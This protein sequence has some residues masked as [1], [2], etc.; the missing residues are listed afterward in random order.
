MW[1]SCLRD[2]FSPEAADLFRL[3]ANENAEDLGE[4]A[5]QQGV[6]GGLVLQEPIQL[7]QEALVFAQPVIDLAHV[8][9][10]EFTGYVGVPENR[11]QA[12]FSV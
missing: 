9:G 12:H 10:Q 6:E 2:T 4:E 11:R 1:R 3:P 8:R 5:G 7:P